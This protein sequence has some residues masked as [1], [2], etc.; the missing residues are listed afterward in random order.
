M[1]NLL[2]CPHGIVYTGLGL[3]FCILT[4]SGGSLTLIISHTSSGGFSIITDFTVFSVPSLLPLFN[5]KGEHSWLA[6]VTWKTQVEPRLSLTKLCGTLKQFSNIA[7]SLGD[8]K[9]QFFLG[10]RIPNAQDIL[11]LP[12]SLA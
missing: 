11:L 2:S 12:M 9:G 6:T 8:K 4:S 7:A 5:T 3:T 1:F 10:R